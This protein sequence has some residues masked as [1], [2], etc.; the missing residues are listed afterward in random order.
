MKYSRKQITLIC[1]NCKNSYSKD[2]S[3]YKRNLKLNRPSY[4]SLKCSSSID[5]IPLEIRKQH[6]F[7]KGHPVPENSVDEFTPFR[8]YLKSCKAHFNEK[9]SKHK[10]CTLTLEDLKN[11][12]DLQKGICPYTKIELKLQTHSKHG[13]K[14]EIDCFHYGSVDRIDSS[15]GYSKDNI[16]FISVGINYMS[17][18]TVSNILDSKL[19]Q[20]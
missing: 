2:E 13:L 12:W 9:K 16:E 6:Y 1:P 20:V 3:E 7:K 17:W 5:N 19:L 14:T 18:T 10:L 11:Q 15:K 4:C 8:Y